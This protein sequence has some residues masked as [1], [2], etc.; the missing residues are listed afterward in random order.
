MRAIL[1]SLVF[2]SMAGCPNPTQFEGAAK[3][4]NGVTGCR[5]ACAADGLDLGRFV[6][7]GEFAT[8]CVCQPA[9][10]AAAAT[11]MGE[12]NP[13]AGVVVQTQAAAAAAAANNSQQLRH[14]RQQ[15]QQ[16]SQ[17]VHH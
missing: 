1:V 15:E 4:P 11:A 2:A 7:S 14:Q 3:F 9:H 13:T 12:A 5:R 17:P 8:S 6:Y 16:Q 10:P